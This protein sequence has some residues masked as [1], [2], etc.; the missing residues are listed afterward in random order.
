[1]I[2]VDAK[3]VVTDWNPAAEGVFGWKADE[4]IGRPLPIVR[5]VRQSVFLADLATDALRSWEPARERRAVRKDGTEI[6]VAVWAA[7]VPALVQSGAVVFVI[8]ADV[9][10]KRQQEHRL[11]ESEERYRCLFEDARDI[12]CTMD[13]AC[14]F[15][16]INRAG[17]EITGY[18]RDELLSMNLAD[19]IS[20]D[21]LAATRSAIARRLEAVANRTPLPD[22]T[23][24]MDVKLKGGRSMRADIRPRVTIEGSRP[25]GFHV[26]VRDVS[27]QERW[28]NA[29]DQKN[30]QLSEAL[31]EARRASE[32]K[33]RFLA[34]MSHEVRTPMN[35][36]I[37]ASELLLADIHL[38]PEQRQYLD[39]IRSSALALLRVIN[40]ILDISKM[41]A[42]KME[43]V[44]LPFEIAAVL[45]D[46]ESFLRVEAAQ[47][48][49]EFRT[50]V[51]A[52]VPKLVCGDAVR[53]RQ[54]LLNLAGN[55]VKFTDRGGVRMHV[56]LDADTLEQV[57]L[58]FTVT[59]SGIGIAK[60]DLARLFDSF[61]Q[62][63]NSPA[64]RHGGTGL[65]LAISKQLV[66]LMGGSIGVE[67]QPGAGSTFWFTAR[68]G[69]TGSLKERPAPAVPFVPDAAFAGTAV[70]VAEDDRVNCAIIT[71]MLQKLG[72]SVKVASNGQQAVEAAAA[73][74]YGLIFMDGQMPVLDGFAATGQIRRAEGGVRHTPIIAVTA[75]AMVGDRERFLTAGMDDYITKP[76]ALDKLA[77][78]LRRWGRS[79]KPATP[80][81][82]PAN[83]DPLSLQPATTSRDVSSAIRRA[84]QRPA[85]GG[86][87]TGQ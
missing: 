70:L 76:L 64:R 23:Y 55:S 30:R 56:A 68:F 24:R 48:G 72:C 51:D 8:I 83:S 17:V 36:V 73:D 63:D 77:L 37:G 39:L 78:V 18:S 67:S 54:I 20:A 86:G 31:D 50:E 75:S 3:G 1:V 6:A 33:S 43:L 34:N 2:G 80:V 9:S 47:K 10:E 4:A 85:P 57:V 87:R 42:G 46:V 82:R 21:D 74:N 5:K 71:R 66:E 27:E 40:D 69:K 35:G 15:T 32:V 60:E 81:K 61:V 25:T 79:A 45:T 52:A 7:P 16:S 65:G 13:M 53:L 44:L 84:A 38:R 12:I 29:L 62:V 28:A 59:D 19:I 22:P 11:R 41:E 14:N 58:R 49:L 26:I